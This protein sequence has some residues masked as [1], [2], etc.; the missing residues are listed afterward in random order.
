[1]CQAGLAKHSARL[2]TLE[3][4]RMSTSNSLS[5]NPVGLFGSIH[6]NWC[7]ASI[8][9][10]K[11]PKKQLIMVSLL[12]IA[13]GDVAYWILMFSRL[14]GIKINHPGLETRE[15]CL[16]R[17]WEKENVRNQPR[18]ILHRLESMRRVQQPAGSSNQHDIGSL[19]DSIWQQL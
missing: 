19:V 5:A 14:L 3:E 2:G 11:L 13:L 10:E 18:L 15:K 12:K 1:M 16:S 6:F 4:K 17:Q 9:E 8:Y 7:I